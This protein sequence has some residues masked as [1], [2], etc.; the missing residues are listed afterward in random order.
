MNLTSANWV[1]Y[2][3][4]MGSSLQIF[5]LSKFVNFTNVAAILVTA[6]S[7]VF[8]ATTAVKKLLSQQKY[9]SV[10]KFQVSGNLSENMSGHLS[11]QVSGHMSIATLK[12]NNR[13]KCH[14]TC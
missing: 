2:Y 10:L 3:N 13:N 4:V 14:D 5:T 11:G 12:D 6:F 1:L 9:C 7:S 8:Y